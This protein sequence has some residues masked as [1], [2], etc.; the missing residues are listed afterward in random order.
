MANT[1]ISKTVNPIHYE[2]LRPELMQTLFQIAG[3]LSQVTNEADFRRLVDLLD[4]VAPLVRIQLNGSPRVGESWGR[5]RELL[6]RARMR[7]AE[8]EGQL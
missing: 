4:D 2:T 3:K 8:L 5:A 6:D 7:L 1:N